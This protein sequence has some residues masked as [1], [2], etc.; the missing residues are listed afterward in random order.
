MQNDQDYLQEELQHQRTLLKTN[1]TNLRVTEE[2]IALFGPANTPLHLLHQREW[3]ESERTKALKSVQ[4]LEQ[5]LRDTRR[6]DG[7]SQRA[8]TPG[9]STEVLLH[10]LPTGLLHLYSR[11]SLPL[12][13]HI[14][15]NPSAAST[16]VVLTSWIEQFSYTCTDTIHLDPGKSHTICQLPILKL[17]EIASIYEVRQAV[18]HTRTSYLHDGQES[19]L[20]LQDYDI[21]FLARDA[22]IW[23]IIVDDTTIHDLSHH[24]AAWV[25]PNAKPVV[26]MLRHAAD[27]HP[28]GQLWGYQDNGAAH[29]R[30]AIVRGQIKAIFQALKEKGEITYIN[31]PISFGRK[32]NEVQQRVNLSVDSLA[33]RQANCIDGAVLY[34]SLIERADMN[35]VIVLVPGHAFVGW[36]TWTGSGQYEFLETT[37]T[38]SHAFEDAFNQGMREFA[39]VQPSIDRPLFDPKGFAVLLKIT[40]LRARGVLPQG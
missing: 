30:A 39:A 38:E 40:E 27:Y 4:K 19:L 34:A 5:Q 33:H 14:V 13:K 25:T 35:P 37:M 6:D 31:S 2:Q 16:T 36:E 8:K 3:A 12:L 9:V 23:A 20:F 11:E 28:T 21:R 15:S 26:K 22:L 7:K 32:A 24:I 17:D 1:T 10:T 18:L 29:Q